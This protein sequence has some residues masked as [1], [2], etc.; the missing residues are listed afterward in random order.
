MMASQVISLPGG[1]IQMRT[2]EL[3]PSLHLAG[4]RVS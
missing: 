4:E 1:S 2:L 3:R